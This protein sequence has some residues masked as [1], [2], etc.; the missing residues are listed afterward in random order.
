MANGPGDETLSTSKNAS[1]TPP[2]HH[3]I[4]VKNA[5]VVQEQLV[6]GFNWIEDNAKIVVAVI[7]IAVLGGLGYA[8]VQIV[9]NRQEKAAQNEYYKVEA[10]FLKKRE[11]FEKTKFK[12]F[13]PAE[14]ADKTPGEIATGD[15]AKDYGAL[16]TGLETT[17]KEYSG[18]A[19]GG[20]AA[21]LTA[22]TYLDYKQ[23]DKAVEYAELAATKL[24][25][26]H[27][28]GLLA[29]VLWGNALAA[30][31]D[32]KGALGVWQKVLDTPAASYLQGD[33]SVRSGVCFEKLGQNDRALEMYRKASGATGGSASSSAAKGLMRAL[34]MKTATK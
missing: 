9:S 17:A 14:S 11:A 31:D 20:Q 13:M 25:K 8:G 26:G 19:A 33:V 18:T 10:P 29:T 23:P 28:L 6:E 2:A 12:A 4:E 1:R 21:I 16:I 27:T 24:P 32:C 15:L 22:Q 5:D 34:E 7:V 30:K 3:R